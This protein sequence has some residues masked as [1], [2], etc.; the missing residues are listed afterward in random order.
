MP[1]A[2][3]YLA[4]ILIWSTTPLA[5][6]WSGTQVGPAFGLALRM[7]IGL[8]LLLLVLRLLRLELPFNKT[9]R[10]VYL[11]GGLPLFIAMSSVYWSAQFIP[12]GWISVIFGL[13]PF[14]TSV[15]ARLILGEQSFAAAKSIGMILALLGLIAVFF[16]SLSLANLAWAGLLGV[17]FSS[18]THSLGAVMLKRL[19]P[20]IHPISVT[21]GSLLVATPLFVLNSLLQGLPT[22]IPD[23]TLAAIVYLAVMGSAIGF[24]LYYF[25]L[26]RLKAE[27][28]SLIT[29]VTPVIALILGATL[30]GESISTQ[31]WMGSLLILLGL[32]IFEYGR[33]LPVAW[34]RL[35]DK[36]GT[37]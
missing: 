22:E 2:S 6:Q 17:C 5:I 15:F 13:T 25:C 16:E 29:L 20:S 9:A 24:P 3:A 26:D 14:F 7:L 28:V 8:S 23:Q 11:T 30:N 36:I 10:R 21:A 19:K 12:S 35:R 27:Q 1:I 18:M 4:V 34:Q 33:L 31:A 32:A 37:T